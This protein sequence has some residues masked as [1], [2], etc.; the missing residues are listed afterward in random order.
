MVDKFLERKGRFVDRVKLLWV[1]DPNHL[2]HFCVI[3]AVG[4][5]S[6]AAVLKVARSTTTT[7]S[8]PNEMQVE[9]YLI[10]ILIEIML[11]HS[12]KFTKVTQILGAKRLYKSD[13][14]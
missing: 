3:S 2:P 11:L 9:F 8:A 4:N 14:T 12:Q 10:T 7:F 13:A 1:K 6:N 5:I